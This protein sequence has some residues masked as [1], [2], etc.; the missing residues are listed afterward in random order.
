[1]I[2]TLPPLGLSCLMASNAALPPPSLSEAM[3]EVAYEGSSVVVSTRMTL[4]PDC[5][6]FSSGDCIAVTSVGAMRMASG[7]AALTE[8]RMGRC[9]VGS[10]FCGPWV[11]TLTP[12][13]AASA[14]APHCMLM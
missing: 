10:N 9:S 5:A 11:V 6:A 4:T 8:S 7:W 1:M 13:L 14:S 2:M 12:S 3:A